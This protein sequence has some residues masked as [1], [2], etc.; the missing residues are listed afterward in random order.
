MKELVIMQNQ[1]AVTTSLQVAE[2]FEKEHRNVLQAIDEVIKGVA[3]KSADLFYEDVYVH[4][5]NKQEYRQVVMNKKGFTLVA[6]GF[7]GKKATQFKLDYIEAFERMEDYIKHQPKLPTSPREIAI[8]TLQANEETN[9]RVDAIEEKVVNLEE[10]Q[11]ITPG[12]YGYISTRIN[13]RVSE[14][15]RGFG[16]ITQ[17]QRGELF[18]DINGGIKKITGVGTRSQLR[19]KHYEAVMEFIQDWEQSTATKRIVRQTRLP[20]DEDVNNDV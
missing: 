2:I 7:T 18:K 16:N 20:I 3:E 1:Q 13:Q 6:M 11:T 12:D 9:Q 14:V 19:V 17:A 5:Q 10:N 4:P 15:A 8:L